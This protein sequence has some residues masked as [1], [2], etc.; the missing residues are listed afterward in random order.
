MTEHG[1]GFPERMKKFPTLRRREFFV[2]Q[3]SC[4][5]FSSSFTFPSGSMARLIWRMCFS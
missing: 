2:L 1:P 3:K 4:Q 5:R